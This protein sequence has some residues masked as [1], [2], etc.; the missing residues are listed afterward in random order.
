[1]GFSYQIR[2]YNQQ[3]VLKNTITSDKVRKKI[4]TAD[5][6][7]GQHTVLVIRGDLVIQK[8]LIINR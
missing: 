3:D 5:L 2:I 7:K 6:A 1:M 4:M 8:Q